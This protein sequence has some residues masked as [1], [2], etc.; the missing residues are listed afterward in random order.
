MVRKKK[1]SVRSF[2]AEPP[3]PDVEDLAGWIRTRIGREGDIVTY[4]LEESLCGQDELD[5][6]C[7]GGLFYKRRVLSSV[8][9][10]EGEVLVE[11]PDLQLDDIRRD[12]RNLLEF[13]RGTWL[14]LPAPSHLGLKDGYFDD[15]EE[16]CAAISG[17]YRRLTR[18]M[19]DAGVSGHILHCNRP[20]EIELE[21]LA[22]RRILFFTH[23]T[24]EEVIE[25]I[26]G[27]QDDLVIPPE[28][29]KNALRWS[30][31]FDIRSITILDPDE[32]D[33]QWAVSEFDPE[34]IAA[35]GYC[36]ENCKDYW[37]KITGNAGVT[38]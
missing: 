13:R 14:A 35:G 15:E 22:G 5:R 12:A 17:L 29:L 19:R 7:A 4:L 23:E 37:R 34:M 18:E 24:D 26:L 8:I 20:G 16:F 38:L 27:Y 32:S 21:E 36:M 6:P 33:L 9:G 3:S 30:D 31:E 2:G 11:E 28:D 25:E 1:I 10:I